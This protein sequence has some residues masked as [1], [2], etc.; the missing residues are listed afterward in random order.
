MRLEGKV[1]FISGGA[2]GMGAVEARLFARQGASVAIGDI[3]EDEG[4]KLEAQIN[5]SGGQALFIRLDAA[6]ESDWQNAIKATVERFGK[7]DILINNAAIYR[8]TPIEE[9][10]VKEWDD[11]M[12]VN[13]RV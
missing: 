2:R 13:L 1:A 7:L 10:S 6:S 4:K 12:A 3:L 11:L 9:T 8:A 5:E